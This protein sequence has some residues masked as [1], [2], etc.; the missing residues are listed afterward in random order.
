[1]GITYFIDVDDLEFLEAIFK[2]KII[3]L[4]QEYFYDNWEKID[5]VLNCNGFVHEIPFESELFKNSDLI[6]EGRKIYELLADNDGKW[7]DPESY[8]AI[9]AQGQGETGEAGQDT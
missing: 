8:Q 4:L 6:D 5:L 1:M 9:Y 7:E 3:P 2:N